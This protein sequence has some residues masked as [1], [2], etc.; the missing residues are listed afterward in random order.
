MVMRTRHITECLMESN[1]LRKISKNRMELSSAFLTR[2][3][4]ISTDISTKVA[5][6]IDLAL[7]HI[8]FLK[9]RNRTIQRP[10]KS[11]EEEDRQFKLSDSNLMLMMKMMEIKTILSLKQSNK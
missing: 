4:S 6:N 9:D 1:S 8:K 10:Q 11:L 2:P 5:V 7:I 3:M